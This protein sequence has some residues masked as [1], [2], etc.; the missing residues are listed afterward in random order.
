MGGPLGWAGGANT[1]RHAHDHRSTGDATAV[2]DC[3]CF[4]CCRCD[5][6]GADC[7]RSRAG[8]SAANEE[9]RKGGVLFLVLFGAN[10]KPACVV[11]T[12]KVNEWAYGTVLTVYGAGV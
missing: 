5:D 1:L 10:L 7:T 2:Q 9:L 11:V 4:R 12:T 6:G 3:S 8:G